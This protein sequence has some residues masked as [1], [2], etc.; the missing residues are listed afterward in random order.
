MKTYSRYLDTRARVLINAVLG[1]Q[2]HPFDRRS[3][4]SGSPYPEGNKQDTTESSSFGCA[5]ALRST[6]NDTMDGESPQ[7]EDFSQIPLVE[8]SQHKVGSEANTRPMEL[9]SYSASADSC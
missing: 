6:S 2:K 4:R 9:Y 3:I 5:R 7:E 8:R 1:Q